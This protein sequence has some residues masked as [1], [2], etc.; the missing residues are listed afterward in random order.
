MFTLRTVYKHLVGIAEHL[1]SIKMIYKHIYNY[2]YMYVIYWNRLRRGV[3][4]YVYISYVYIYIYIYI[5]YNYAYRYINTYTGVAW[6]NT[7]NE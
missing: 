2:V 7:W 5:Y 1:E 6:R 3:H 4:V